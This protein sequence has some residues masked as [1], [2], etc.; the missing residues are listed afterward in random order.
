MKDFQK[1]F[2]LVLEELGTGKLGLTKEVVEERLKRDGYNQLEEAKK[3]S[4]IV[5]FFEQFK[6]FLVIILI[7]SA[8][9]SGFFGESKS[10][11][12][13]CVVIIINAI[14]GLVQHLKAESSLEGL[15]KLSSPTAK[16]VR[17][18]EKIIIPANELVVGDIVLLDAGDHISADGRLIEASSLQIIE[19]SLT[20]ES[21]AVEKITEAIDEEDV[22]LGDMT[23]MVF[24]SGLVSYGR[25]KFVVTATGMDTQI[26][27]IAKLIQSAKERKTPLQDRLD[28]FGKKLGMIIMG[29]A[30]VIFALNMYRGSEFIDAF[31]FA[32]ALAVAAIPEALSSIVTIVLSVG[33]KNMAEKRAIVKK[34]PAVETLGAA[35]IICSDKTGTL[36]QNKMTVM[37][38]YSLSG[39]DKLPHDDEVTAQLLRISLLANDGAITEEGVEIG[40][41]TETALIKYANKFGMS[42]QMEAEML[43]RLGELPFDSDRKLMSTSHEVGNKFYLFTK[44]APDVILRRATKI[45]SHDGALELTDELRKQFSHQNEMYSS[46]G[47]RV[48]AF[49]MREVTSSKL[50]FED[51]NQLTFLGLLAMIDPPRE[52]VKMAVDQAKSAGI[53]TIMITGDHKVTAKA[54][55]TELGIFEEG[56][57]AIDSLEFE[58]MSQEEYEKKLEDIRVYARVS[59]E[60]KIRIVQAWQ[61]RGEIVAMTGDGVND[62][63]ALKQSDIGVAMGITGTEVSKDASAMVLQDDNFATII[64]AVA[65]GRTVYSNIKRAIQFLLSGNTAGIIAVVFSAIIGLPNP[66][67]AIHLLFINLVTD[68]LPAIAMAFEKHDPMV[69]KSFPRK[70]NESIF[71]GGMGKLI[72]VQGFCIGVVT[73]IGFYI[74]LSTGDLLTAQTMAF[75]VLCISRLL[76]GFS[77]RSRRSLFKLGLFSN[78]YMVGAVVV[79]LILQGLVLTNTFLMDI[80]ETVKIPYDLLPYLVILPFI[81]MVINEI[82]KWTL[83][84]EYQK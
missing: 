33:T 59:P 30:V 50:S 40:D 83:Y 58:S 48:L 77:V 15:K 36:T 51:E 78:M 25:G 55:A 76:H 23:N 54:I 3:K 66:F 57:L 14:L 27:K 29:V 41:P 53:T 49:A 42:Q 61:K 13:I 84:R 68:S 63:P 69:M 21:T 39:E 62:A 32:V 79:G 17:N 37:H 19:S 6:D 35:S 74:G 26:G 34:L 44:G 18:G 47:L 80:F 65:E 73:L 5:M 70:K 7:I 20:G 72:I 82:L 52:E 12:T 1:D 2:A 4:L 31:M 67:S 16:V 24:S 81:P 9:V 8:G 28:D 22:P 71:S 38:S 75:S 46:K 11:I 64:Q 45:L 56:N 43:P 60:D 10:A